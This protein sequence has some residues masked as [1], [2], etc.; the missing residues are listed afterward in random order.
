MN[1]N[2]T[3]NA[4][5]KAL[6]DNGYDAI[7]D[8]LGYTH[9]PDEDHDVVQS[10]IEEAFEQM[11]E[12]ELQKFLAKYGIE[13]EAPEGKPDPIT[14]MELVLEAFKHDVL[15]ALDVHDF[16]LE[17]SRAHNIPYDELWITWE[18]ERLGKDGVKKFRRP[19]ANITAETVNDIRA[20]LYD[21]IIVIINQR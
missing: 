1:D 4:L 15:N 3:L 7:T 18:W 21:M 19:G 11:P 10:R 12:E 9:N 13:E 16:Y 6:F 17:I 5:S 2:P 20:W 14:D 8:F